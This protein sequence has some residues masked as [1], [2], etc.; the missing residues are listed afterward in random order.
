[1]TEVDSFCFDRDRDLAR[2]QA[3]MVK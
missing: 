1:M 3:P 2:S